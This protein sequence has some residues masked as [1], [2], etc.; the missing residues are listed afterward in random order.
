LVQVVQ[1]DV[2]VKLQVQTQYFLHLH[3]LVAVAVVT[4]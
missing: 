4:L 3:P 2:V 1:V